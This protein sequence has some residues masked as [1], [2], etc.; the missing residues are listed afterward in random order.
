[1]LRN[2]DF[3]GVWKTDDSIRIKCYSQE[4]FPNF[5]CGCERINF[6]LGDAS[7]EVHWD[8][9]GIYTREE[10]SPEFPAPV[11]KMGGSPSQYLYSHHPKG[12]LWLVG[13]SPVTW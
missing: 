9:A 7:G 1:M 4:V 8:K 5:D 6:T 13:S 10:P 3:I 12:R 2:A 11:F